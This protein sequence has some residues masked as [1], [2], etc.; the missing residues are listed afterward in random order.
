MPS[1]AIP[2]SRPRPLLPRSLVVFVALLV[3]AT[4]VEA[5][6][7]LSTSS[8]QSASMSPPVAPVLPDAYVISG[9][10]LNVGLYNGSMTLMYDWNAKAQVS[11]HTQC[12]AGDKA[13]SATTCS[14]IMKN[15]QTYVM[16]AA[17]EPSCCRFPDG[18]VPIPSPAA[19][20]TWTYKGNVTMGGD[21]GYL[22]M[23]EGFHWVIDAIT[24]QPLQFQFGSGGIFQFN[25]D[26]QPVPSVDPVHYKMP[27]SCA[28]V[29]CPFCW[30]SC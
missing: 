19:Y 3:I 26:L 11:L 10:A 21:K 8:T 23:W 12:I 2:S 15:N 25:T 7:V 27:D 22:F 4:N 1:R 14:I 20:S 9:E 18:D 16:S 28:N 24:S 6:T 5:R 13:I 30:F 29:T 17:M